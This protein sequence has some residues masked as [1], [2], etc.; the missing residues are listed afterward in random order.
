MCAE[1]ISGD[2]LHRQQPRRHRHAADPDTIT[3]EVVSVDAVA[4]ANDGRGAGLIIR[5]MRW[6]LIDFG[7]DDDAFDLVPF[8]GR[9]RFA[10]GRRSD[11]EY[12]TASMDQSSYAI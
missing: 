5:Q 7:G 1:R 3:F 11:R 2:L 10:A 8:T 12:V 6:R 9:P 4:I